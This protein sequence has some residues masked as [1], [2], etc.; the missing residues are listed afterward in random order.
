MIANEKRLKKLLALKEKRW[1]LQMVRAAQIERDL[2]AV[3]AQE[4][5]LMSLLDEGGAAG[6]IFAEL[7]LSK[8]RNA[9][10]QKQTVIEALTLERRKAHAAGREAKQLDKLAKKVSADIQYEAAADQLRQAIDISVHP[11]RVRLP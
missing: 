4:R 10:L 7:T 11:S 9:A 1:K 8:L 6:A 3:S 5:N 2:N